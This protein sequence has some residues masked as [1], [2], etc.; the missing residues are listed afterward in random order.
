MARFA[1]LTPSF[2]VVGPV[3]T[4]DNRDNLRGYALDVSQQMGHPTTYATHTDYSVTD[5]AAVFVL[6][7]VTELRDASTLVLVGEALA[8]GIPVLEPQGPQAAGRCDDCGQAQTIRTVTD[9]YGDTL[10]ATCRGEAACAW[11]GEGADESTM[12]VENGATW[13]P[14]HSGCARA[15]LPALV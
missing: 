12:L 10:C 15:V 2:L 14:A 7:S 13:I 1:N 11:C 6:G 5:F 3:E 8:A 4:D 9:E